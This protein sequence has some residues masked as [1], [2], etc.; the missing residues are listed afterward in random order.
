LAL[1]VPTAVAG[2]ARLT[3][4]E[5]HLLHAMVQEWAKRRAHS[6][7]LDEPSEVWR[8]ALDAGVVTGEQVEYARSWYG[9]QWSRRS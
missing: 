3:G 6:A 2:G 9:L 5:W 1:V 7:L 4:Q 8:L